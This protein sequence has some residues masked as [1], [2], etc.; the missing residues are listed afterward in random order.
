MCVHEIVCIMDAVSHGWS[1]YNHFMQ[2]AVIMYHLHLHHV[3][4]FWSMWSEVIFVCWRYVYFVQLFYFIYRCLI[5]G[6]CI[7]HVVH[8]SFV[9]VVQCVQ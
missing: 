7:M 4:S 2:C 8:F 5:A 3:D 6:V 9:I 1:L